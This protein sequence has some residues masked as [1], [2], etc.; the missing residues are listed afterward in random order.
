MKSKFEEPII[1]L[2]R[3]Q[4]N[5]VITTSTGGLESDDEFTGGGKDYGDLLG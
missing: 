4:Q 1:E 3:L 2:I 5:D